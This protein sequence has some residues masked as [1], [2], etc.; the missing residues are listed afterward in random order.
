VS[1]EESILGA[2]AGEMVMMVGSV[3]ATIFMRLN[4]AVD[5]VTKPVPDLLKCLIPQDPTL[6]NKHAYSRLMSPMTNLL[7]ACCRCAIS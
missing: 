7:F 4:L 1:G 2:G 5:S 6:R 3:N